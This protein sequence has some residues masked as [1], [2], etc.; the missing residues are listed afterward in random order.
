MDNIKFSKNID[1]Q[2]E[3]L[4]I[5]CW[6]KN[7]FERSPDSHCKLE[8]FLNAIAKSSL[9]DSLMNLSIGRH[10]LKK[11]YVKEVANIVGLSDLYIYGTFAD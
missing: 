11:E 2:I 8:L 1:F 5:D 4:E 6:T 3:T 10:Y 7:Y 9:K